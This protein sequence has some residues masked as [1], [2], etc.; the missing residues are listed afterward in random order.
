ME[1]RRLR[2]CGLIK[3]CDIEGGTEARSRV[4][5]VPLKCLELLRIIIFWA[6]KCDYH[7]TII[8]LIEG[9]SPLPFF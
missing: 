7:L 6:E 1:P 5:V 2:E 9:S 4:Q 3:F 8:W